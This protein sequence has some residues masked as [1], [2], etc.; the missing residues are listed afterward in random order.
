MLPSWQSYD[1]QPGLWEAIRWRKV[2]NG[3]RK[4]NSWE[5]RHTRLRVDSAVSASLKLDANVET[6]EEKKHTGWKWGEVIFESMCMI[7]RNVFK[8]GKQKKKGSSIALFCLGRHGHLVCMVVQH[9]L[10]CLTCRRHQTTLGVPALIFP[11]FSVLSFSRLGEVQQIPSL[12]FVFSFPITDKTRE[13]KIIRCY[14][15]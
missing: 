11:F 4:T 2:L 9:A 14:I 7:H 13:K 15:L 1:P 10:C 5:I 8:K 6:K 12:S 3:K